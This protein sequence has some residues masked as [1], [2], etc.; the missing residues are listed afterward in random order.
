VAEAPLPAVAGETVIARDMVGAAVRA[1]PELVAQRASIRAQALNLRAAEKWLLPSLR[2]GADASY[3]GQEWAQPGWGASVGV[4]L[5]WNIFDGFAS[6]ATVTSERAALG[7]EQARLVGVEQAL[8]QEVETARI[9]LASAEA[10]RVAV[11]QGIEA[12]REL[13]RLAQERY[14]AGVGSSLE[15]TDAELELTNASA[16]EVRV[17]NDVAAA[18]AQLLRALGR[19]NWQ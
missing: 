17:D 12:A 16:A 1:R 4:S 13:Q 11:V 18:R 5:S 6:P 14:A 2:L 9:A 10:Q 8:W 3:F 7:I 15:L 19:R